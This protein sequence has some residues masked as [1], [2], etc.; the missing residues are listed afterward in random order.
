MVLGWAILG[1]VSL[2]TLPARCAW[3]GTMA[4]LGLLG[5]SPLD[6]HSW[7]APLVAVVTAFCFPVIVLQTGGS[8]SP[9]FFQGW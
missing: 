8:Q 4:M 6:E 5:R 3:G 9:L 7:H 2:T 1:Q